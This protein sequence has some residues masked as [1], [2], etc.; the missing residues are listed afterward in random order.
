MR[1]P[2]AAATGT[3]GTAMGPSAPS[4]RSSLATCG[5]TPGGT[6][7]SRCRTTT[8]R[9]PASRAQNQCCSRTPRPSTPPPAPRPDCGGLAAAGHALMSA[10][11]PRRRHGDPH[12]PHH[13]RHLLLRRLRLRRRHP[14]QA[15]RWR[16]RGRPVGCLGRPCLIRPVQPRSWRPAQELPQTQRE[17]Q[18]PISRTPPQRQL[19]APVSPWQRRWRCGT[20]GDRAGRDT[21][22][23]SHHWRA[24]NGPRSRHAWA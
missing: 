20:R 12:H 8:P 1:E 24:N 2:R 18:G 14:Q 16:R 10:P 11:L 19:A 22:R 21:L 23:F 17:A 7:G 15:L 5:C 4:H 9:P 3:R 13:H 6:R